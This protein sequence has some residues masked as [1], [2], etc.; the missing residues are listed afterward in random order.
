MCGHARAVSAAALHP[1]DDRLATAAED[2]AVNVWNLDG[3]Y[4]GGGRELAAETACAIKDALC[5]GAGFVTLTG[6][7]GGGEGGEGC[8]ALAVLA[9]DAEMLYLLLESD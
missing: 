4:A 5:C 3:V 6:A 1:A 7:E 8:V 2:G 9:H